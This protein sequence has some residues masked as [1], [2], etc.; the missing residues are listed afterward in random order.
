MT[1]HF[2]WGK[3]QI[4]GHGAQ[5]PQDTASEFPRAAQQVKNPTSIH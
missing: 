5:G 4:P 1:F 3:A 2:F